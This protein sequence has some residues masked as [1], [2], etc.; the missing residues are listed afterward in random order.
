MYRVDKISKTIL[1]AKSSV[2]ELYQGKAYYDKGISN[3]NLRNIAFPANTYTSKNN[4]LPHNDYGGIYS[5]QGEY[6]TSFSVSGGFIFSGFSIE[7]SYVPS[8]DCQKIVSNLYTS[9][10][11]VSVGDTTVYRQVGEKFGG[12]RKI[13]FDRSVIAEACNKEENVT[14]KFYTL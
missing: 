8:A 2:Q 1:G 3:G 11:A 12:D 5:I 4:G 9:F 7:V 10:Q 6:A 13:E 14:I